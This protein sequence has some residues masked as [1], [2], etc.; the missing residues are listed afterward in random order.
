LNGG[1]ASIKV[2]AMTTGPELAAPLTGEAAEMPASLKTASEDI[3]RGFVRKVYGILAIQLVFTTCVAYPVASMSKEALQ[4][5]GGMISILSLACLGITMCTIMCCSEY[6]R[7]YPWN[8]CIL[9]LLTFG[10]GLLMG[11]LCTFY[12][13]PSIVLAAGITGVTFI[14]LTVYAWNTKSDVTGMG[15]YVSAAIMVLLLASFALVFMQWFGLQMPLF[16]KAIAVMGAMVFA[17]YI[18]Y[19]TQLMLGSWGGHKVEF[20][21]DD[22]V[23]AAINLYLDLINL[24]QYI[25]ELIGTRD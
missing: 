7:I 10:N 21:V 19:D 2:A 12:T 17:F 9:A 16:Q 15:M 20:S 22:Y 25:L 14:S 5:E 11:L 3:R 23:F 1:I 6:C 8:Y 24:F 18:V 4:L 13:A